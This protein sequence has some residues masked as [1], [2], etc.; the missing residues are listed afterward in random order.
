MGQ[1]HAMSCEVLE[2]AH[3]VLFCVSVLS[4]LCVAYLVDLSMDLSFTR[5]TWLRYARLSLTARMLMLV[6]PVNSRVCRKIAP[7]HDA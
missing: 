7:W 4:G 1:G 2:Q 3:R 5:S 6:W